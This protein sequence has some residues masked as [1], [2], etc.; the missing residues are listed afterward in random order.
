MTLTGIAAD[1]RLAGRTKDPAARRVI[2]VMAMFTGALVGALLVLNVDLVLPLALGCRAD[3][4]ER[5]CRPR[6]FSAGKPDWA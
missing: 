4:R 6:G 3:G 5:G 1:S 2:P